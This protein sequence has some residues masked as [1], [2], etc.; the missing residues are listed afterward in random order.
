MA[1]GVREPILSRSA[2]AE[3]SQR[4]IKAVAD[5]LAE[6]E[7]REPGLGVR[8]LAYVLDG[9]DNDVLLQIAA[10]QNSRSWVGLCSYEA[11][12]RVRQLFLEF[13][14]W[15]SLAI[16]RLGEVIAAHLRS[17]PNAMR[18]PGGPESP[19][20]FRALLYALAECLVGPAEAPRNSPWMLTGPRCLE[21]LSLGGANQTALV[22][23]IFATLEGVQMGQLRSPTPLGHAGPIR[24][25]RQSA[26][27]NACRRSLARCRRTQPLP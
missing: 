16:K 10:P 8:A 7:R 9:A 4:D 17:A 1:R 25:V 2:A 12:G 11:R 13:E 22:G 5:Y 14:G 21:L 20:F 18:L 23:M 19:E 27:A 26:G 15:E 3:L 6:M 24:R